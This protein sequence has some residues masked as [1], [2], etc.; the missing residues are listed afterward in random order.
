[1]EEAFEF[2]FSSAN[3]GSLQSCYHGVYMSIVLLMAA[4]QRYQYLPKGAVDK[5]ANVVLEP[6]LLSGM[7]LLLYRIRHN[8]VLR[9]I[10]EERYNEGSPNIVGVAEVPNEL[11]ELLDSGTYFQQALRNLPARICYGFG[12]IQR[13]WKML[14]PWIKSASFADIPTQNLVTKAFDAMGRDWETPVF[15]KLLLTD[16]QYSIEQVAAMVNEIERQYHAGVR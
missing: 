15:E 14:L 7:G 12:R 8:P 5:F 13:K 3:A 11:K 4:T 6:L 9:S 1:M 2:K 16:V 10:T